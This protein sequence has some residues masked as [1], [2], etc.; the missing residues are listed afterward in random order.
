MLT[1]SEPDAYQEAYEEGKKKR[2]TPATVKTLWY[3]QAIIAV[4]CLARRPSDEIVPTGPPKIILNSPRLAELGRRA[5]A[6]IAVTVK[7]AA[8]RGRICPRSTICATT[9]TQLALLTVARVSGYAMYLPLVLVFLT[10]AHALRTVL[11]RSFLR[12]PAR[13]VGATGRGVRARRRRGDDVDIPWGRRGYAAAAAMP[14]VMHGR[15]DRRHPTDDPRSGRRSMRVPF[16]D[17]HHL[18]TAMGTFIAAV[19]LIHAAAHLVRWGLE[20]EMRFLFNSRSG[21]TG[22]ICLLCLPLIVFPPRGYSSDGSRRRRGC[23]VDI[24]WRRVAATWSQ[25][26]A[27]GT[28]H[29]VGAAPHTH[30][31]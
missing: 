3:V 25:A 9:P 18:H 20:N 19:T 17:L 11:D 26:H 5:Q 31:V 6:I 30:S 29:G 14:R 28:A 22:F 13:I 8:R 15:V 2:L 4:V 7:S 10:K 27:S 16:N 24:L 23:D 21:V 12:R 1:L